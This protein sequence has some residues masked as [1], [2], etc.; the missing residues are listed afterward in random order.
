MFDRD[1]DVGI[2]EGDDKIGSIKRGLNGM[3]DMEIEV[4]TIRGIRGIRGKKI[5]VIH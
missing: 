3:I 2:I 4:S 1:G 5:E